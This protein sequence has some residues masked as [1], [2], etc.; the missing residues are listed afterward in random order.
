MAFTGRPVVTKVSDRKFRITGLTLAAGAFGDVGFTDNN[1]T[2]PS[3]D[4]AL[5]APEWQPYV[6]AEGQ[7]VS[8]Q[9]AIEAR[10]NPLTDVTTPVPISIVKSGV[11]HS[12][13]LG[14]RT[15]P[16]SIPPG[17]RGP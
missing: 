4:V 17:R 15:M 10:C 2:P 14:L 12:G 9:D 7:Q 6:N 5:P 8:L 11:D 13:E 3:P 16:P 1:L